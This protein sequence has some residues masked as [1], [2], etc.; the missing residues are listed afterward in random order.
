MG[1]TLRQADPESSS[2][3]GHQPTKEDGKIA[4]SEDLP[5]GA[6]TYIYDRN[7]HRT[8]NWPLWRGIASLLTNHGHE[9]KEQRDL[10][11]ILYL[12]R[13]PFSGGHGPGTCFPPSF[14][15]S[16]LP[17]LL[18]LSLFLF[19]MCFLHW[20]DPSWHGVLRRC[21]RRL[22]SKQLCRYHGARNGT[23]RTGRA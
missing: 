16:I 3:L 4:P 15:P 12:V 8:C 6:S 17:S 7:K 23:G 9:K 13:N 22:T 5:G 20:D 11:F 10:I 18:L 1:Y 19:I 2:I 14:P 21:G